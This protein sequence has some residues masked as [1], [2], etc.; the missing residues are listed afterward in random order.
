MMSALATLGVLVA[1]LIVLMTMG[2]PVFFAMGLSALAFIGCLNQPIPLNVLASSIV[3]GMDSSLLIAIPLFFFAAEL[4]AESGITSR[5]V[6]LAGALAGHVS[7]GLSQ[8][9]ILTTAVFSGVSGTAIADAAAV[10]AAM[11]PSMKK[12]G[13]PPAY[14]AALVAAASAMGPIIPPSMVFIIY[15]DFAGVSVGRMFMAGVIPGA[16]ICA[17]LLVAAWMTARQRGFPC[18]PAASVGVR[19]TRLREAALAL[20]MPLL[21]MAGFWSGVATATEVGALATA[22]AVVIGTLVYKELT[23]RAI[24]KAAH[25]SMASAG[26]VLLLVGA[27]GTYSWLIANL[28]LGAALTELLRG[29]TSNPVVVL[30]LLNAAFLILGLAIEGI[31][32]M[33]AIVPL[34]LP[35]IRSFEI[36]LVQFG[37]IVVLNLTIGQLTPPTGLVTFLTAQIAD[38]DPAAVFREALPFIAALVTALVAV[39]FIPSVSLW[40]PGVAA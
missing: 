40:L 19:M 4:M 23:L 20:A 11:I 37:V 30:L 6:A 17:F 35:L 33:I 3:Q 2:V 22:Y 27:A 16:L 25:R 24:W 13:Y 9:A 32:A 36:D 5:L 39:T 26:L 7:G 14:A 18:E 38:V 15:A 12:Q 28:S 29:L 34:V 8:V 31:A 21:I 10:G 1:A